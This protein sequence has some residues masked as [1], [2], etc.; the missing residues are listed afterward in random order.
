MSDEQSDT[1]A[2][3]SDPTSYGLA[4]GEIDRLETHA[5]I[6]FLAGHRAYK[7]KRAV[8][9]PYLDFSTTRRRQEACEVEVALNRRT[10]PDLYL[11]VRRIVRRPDGRPAWDDEGEVLDWVVCMRRFEQ[12]DLLDHVARATGLS[13][14][15]LYCAAALRAISDALARSSAAP[16]ASSKTRSRYCLPV[17]PRNAYSREPRSRGG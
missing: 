15:L 11:G 5:S 9:Y 1:I 10:A 2:F 17:A 4:S 12:D 14:P 7:L 16:V 8:K 6:V 3:L 13:P